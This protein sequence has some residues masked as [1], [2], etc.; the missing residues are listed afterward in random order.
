MLIMRLFAPPLLIVAAIITFG[1]GILFAE[2]P[3]VDDSKTKNDSNWL[4][5]AVD[6]QEKKHEDQNKLDT[7]KNLLKDT[8]SNG[9]VKNADIPNPGDTKSDASGKSVVNGI[10]MPKDTSKPSPDSS[11]NNSKSTDSKLPGSL[12]G[13]KKSTNPVI[14]PLSPFSNYTTTGI[15]NLGGATQAPTQSAPTPNDPAKSGLN[16]GLDLPKANP[17]L[18]LPDYQTSS[19]PAIAPDN[20]GQNYY[21]NAVNA[22][23]PATSIKAP[24]SNSMTSSDDYLKNM[25]NQQNQPLQAPQTS[26]INS[27]LSSVY[28]HSL[29]PA[30]RPSQPLTL[31]LQPPPHRTIVI[32]NPGAGQT[33]ISDPNDFLNR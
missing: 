21:G 29:D 7:D 27:G 28:G 18:A 12:P 11:A 9:E 14:A 23:N 20:G 15:S 31:G 17:L 3:P 25:Y 32:S 10:T 2:D 26:G 13:E 19:Q 22:M 30:P 16:F 5:N 33:H 4:Q 1:G 24:S 8:E 6:E